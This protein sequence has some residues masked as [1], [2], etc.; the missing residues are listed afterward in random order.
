CIGLCLFKNGAKACQ[1]GRVRTSRYFS[2]LP[3]W[4][5]DSQ[6]GVLL[7]VRCGLL[8]KLDPCQWQLHSAEGP[9]HRRGPKS[10][11]MACMLAIPFETRQGQTM[12]TTE[13]RSAQ[14]TLRVR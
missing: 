4:Q 8:D 7:C 10:I 12:L 13:L 6:W 11:A 2:A 5:F 9:A 14:A 1:R 3:T